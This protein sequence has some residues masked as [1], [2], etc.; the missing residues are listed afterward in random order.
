VAWAAPVSARCVTACALLAPDHHRRQ[1][2]PEKVL[3]EDPNKDDDNKAE[4]GSHDCVNY[5]TNA[6][7]LSSGIVCNAR[8]D[9]LGNS[10]KVTVPRPLGIGSKITDRRLTRPG[11]SLK[12]A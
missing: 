8:S 1:P 12:F 11:L 2:K 4:R 6:P 5:R 3:H 9:A 10:S 7:G